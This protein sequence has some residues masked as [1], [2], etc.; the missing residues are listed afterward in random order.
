MPSLPGWAG[1]RTPGDALAGPVHAGACSWRAPSIR[2]RRGPR[3][4]R[5]ACLRHASAPGTA[6]FSGGGGR[7]GVRPPPSRLPGV[8]NQGRPLLMIISNQNSASDTGTL[9]IKCRVCIRRA[10]SGHTGVCSEFPGAGKGGLSCRGPL[11]ARWLLRGD[12]S[13]S[14]G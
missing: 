14:A 8:G 10:I 9:L 6:L 13:A 5:R 11:T 7:S 1:G 4:L 2:S 3:G 12:A